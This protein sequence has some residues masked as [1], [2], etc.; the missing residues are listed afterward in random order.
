MAAYQESV[1]KANEQTRKQH[2]KDLKE[3]RQSGAYTISLLQGEYRGERGEFQQNKITNR[4]A[5]ITGLENQVRQAEA[6]LRMNTKESDKT[7]AYCMTPCVP[8]CCSPG[9]SRGGRGDITGNVP[10]QGFTSLSPCTHVLGAYG[11]P[12][13]AGGGAAAPPRAVRGRGRGASHPRVRDRPCCMAASGGAWAKPAPDAPRYS[14]RPK[15]KM[16]IAS[17]GGGG[18]RG[19]IALFLGELRKRNKITLLMENEKKPPS[20]RKT[21]DPSN[22]RHSKHP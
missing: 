3:E 10:G 14:G 22:T 20:L 5:G 2:L 13:G 6:Y 12:T 15:A 17:T 8:H 11:A 18:G 4:E 16:P 1:E 9:Y 7:Y 21:E 19:C